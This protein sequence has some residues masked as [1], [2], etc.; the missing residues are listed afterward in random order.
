M[1]VAEASDACRF[2]TQPEH[3][4][5]VGRFADRWG[6]ETFAQP[7]PS[8]PVTMAAA[9]HD[10]GWYDYDL[11]PHLVDGAPASVLDTTRAEWSRFY[12]HGIAT[13]AERDPYAGLLCAMHGAGVRKQRY[14]TQSAL[15]ATADEF[16]DFID[17]QEKRQRRLLDALDGHPVYATHVDDADRR[18]LDALHEGSGVDP[19]RSGDSGVFRNYRLLQAWD[20]LSLYCCRRVDREPATIRT[21]LSPGD[22]DVELT[23]TPVDDG[24]RVEPY[25]FDTAPLTTAVDARVVPRAAFEPG[26]EDGLVRAYYDAPL[27]AV[28]FRFVA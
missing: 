1:L 11:A 15:P 22:P 21:P 12:D 20:R 23:L 13:V 7:A 6:N 8:A 2:I 18:T 19:E 9:L 17:E 4:T 24:V 26:D 14:G 28:T 5:Q 10:A 3:G 25:P 27:D 16:A